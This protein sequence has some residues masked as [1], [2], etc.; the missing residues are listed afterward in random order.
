M[1]TLA[2]I[3]TKPGFEDKLMRE[4]KNKNLIV[5]YTPF[6]GIL[7]IKGDELKEIDSKY[8]FK[9]I[10]VEKEG[11]L[12]DIEN[13]ILSLIKEKNPKGRFVVRCNRRGRHSFTSEELERR[14]GKIINELGYKVD[15]ENYDFKVNV[16]ILQDKVYLSIFDKNFKEIVYKENIKWLEKINK[17]K[18]RPLNRAENK[19]REIIKKFPYIFTNLDIV[20][21]IGSA[22][23]GWVKVLSEKA[24]K[25]YAIDPGELKI[26]KSNI[27]HI[28]K[29]AEEVYINESLDL[30]TNDTNLYPLESFKL[31]ER[32][33]DN[34]KVGKFIIYTL[35]AEDNKVKE[36]LRDVLNYL[37]S[38][39]NLE[40]VKVIKLKSNTKNERTLIIKKVG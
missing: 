10:P 4:L 39:D 3:T 19:I 23:G 38:F 8:I 31:I 35:K 36:N 17:Y 25:V 5:K 14:L 37:D 11:D 9:L 20:L 22:P 1:K 34:L 6:R 7:K 33:L 12:K 18:V 40:L 24:K 29:R 27:I 21:D 28:K 30:I 13:L 32:F 16:E 26:K 2:L 15:L